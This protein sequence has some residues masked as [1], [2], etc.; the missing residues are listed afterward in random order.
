M[1]LLL[2]IIQSVYSIM[3]LPWYFIWGLSFMVFDSG[4]SLWGIGI[5]ISVTL[6]P[7][8]AVGC[9]ILSWIF[10]KKIKPLYII[11]INFVPA[12]WIIAFAIVLFVL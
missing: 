11:K 1:K 3:L 9:S 8:A 4:I 6:Y 2:I 10:L 5:M 12:I 7:V